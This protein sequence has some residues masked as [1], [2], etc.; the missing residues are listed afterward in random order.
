MYLAIRIGILNLLM[1]PCFYNPVFAQDGGINQNS[2]ELGIYVAGDETIFYGVNAKFI[3]P[4]T[5]KK[6][7]PTLGFSL[8]TY[9]DLKGE[10]ESGAYLKNDVD[11]RIIPA[12]NP[13]YS[14]NFK[15]VQLNFELPVG[16]SIV[17]TKG[18]LINER[19]GFSRDY[20]NTELLWHYGAAFSPKYR[21]N[22]RNQIGFNIFL[23]LVQ[24][25]AISGYLF[26]IGWAKTFAIHKKSNG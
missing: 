25:K 6:H 12:L 11:M 22:K 1:A 13:G 2:L 17:I 9:F 20:S 8:T 21:L 5:Q 19:I 10:S 23:P 14:F 4:I 24:D 16:A 3:I 26:G 7:Y 18:S 15:R